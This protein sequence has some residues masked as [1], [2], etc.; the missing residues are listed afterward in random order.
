[1]TDH[2]GSRNPQEIFFQ[3]RFG[4]SKIHFGEIYF[5]MK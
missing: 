1:M 3:N 2:L 5:I 4:T